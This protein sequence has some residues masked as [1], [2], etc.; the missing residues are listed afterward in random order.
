MNVAIRDSEVPKAG[1]KQF[2]WNS[3]TDNS[4]Y[5]NSRDNGHIELE[6]DLSDAVVKKYGNDPKV[7]GKITF[8]GVATD[9]GVLKAINVYIPGL[10]S[11]FVTVATRE[12]NGTWTPSGTL[13]GNGWAWEKVSETFTQE[14]GHIVEFMLHWN[15]AKITNVAAKDVNVQVQAIDRGKASWNGSAVVYTSNAA[16][17]TGPTEAKKATYQMDVVPYIKGLDTTLTDLE[18]N[19][20]SVYGR[21][22]L[23]KYPVYYYRQT[24][25]PGSQKS[26]KII[27]D[28]FNIPS[29]SEITFEGGATA[30]LNNDMSFTLP[31]N[32]K[33]GEIKVTVKNIEPLKNIE[34]LNNIN[35]NDAKGD[36]T[37]SSTYENHYNRQPNGQNNDLLTDNVELAIWEMNSRAAI[38]E[39]GELSEVVMH[40]N[41][42][43]G[44]VGLAFA[45][46]QDL[47]SYPNRNKANNS[48]NSYQTWITDW[49]GVNQIGFVYDKDG[50]MFGTN[51][52]TDTY[53]PSKKTGRL[54]LISSHWGIIA[55]ESQSSDDY[56]G[57]TK[58]RRLRLEYLGLSRNGVYASN[59]NRFAKGDC[60]QLATTTSGNYTNLYMMYYDNT[61]GE[62]KFKA[63]AYDN[64]WSYGSGRRDD[65]NLETFSFNKA[66]FSFGDF[67][68]DAYNEHDNDAG[69]NYEP[70]YVTTSIV[71]NQS[72]ANGDSSVR[73][74]IYY[75]I[76]VVP[77]KDTVRNGK[78]TTTDVV[79]AVWY[80]DVNKTL[81]YSY[82]ENP[83]DY[84][85][86]RT[87]GG[88]RDSNG[89][90]TEWT[91]PIPILDGHAGGYCAIKADDKGGIHI[92]AYSRKDAGSLYYA[93]LADHTSEPTVVPVDTYGS[94]G[95][96]I[97]MEVAYAGN[98]KYIPYIG[99]YMNSMS[100]P[101]Y[102]YLVDTTSGIKAGVS[103]DNTYTGA[104]ETILLP[105]ESSIV[106]DDINIGIFKKDDGTLGI[107][108]TQTENAGAKN[109]IAGGNGTSNPIFAYGIAQTG[110]GYI[111]TAQLK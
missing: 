87:A 101:K 31:E 51:G 98:E 108:P 57:Y 67:A 26:E 45:H 105:T 54:G 103:D 4:L 93:Y 60:T 70:N 52:G 73:P 14:T 86:N 16:S 65:V 42:K 21:T 102:A 109:G 3:E 47:A 88:K 94:T 78:V 7:S 96:Y 91:T 44:M 81:W 66:D 12:D 61:L 56:S 80:D 5:Q 41:P 48:Y 32:A 43:N 77:G 30:T 39:T 58:Y 97:T 84:A 92:A 18:K 28:G 36:Y 27:L 76:S 100:Y 75:S 1:F 24:T 40:V 64:T 19:N 9:N 63:G 11:D 8:R 6:G 68:D 33:S 95:Q 53:T 34:S 15:T 82:L 23:G 50:N 90:S 99:Y 89:V 72:G 79:V 10:T 104:W 17:T 29:G 69:T 85:G 71:A 49:T 110:S 62:L 107:I 2:Y 83:L 55:T 22:S 74:G 25:T 13:D 37:G 59:V 20:P 38:A 35:N 111:E 46:S 106:L